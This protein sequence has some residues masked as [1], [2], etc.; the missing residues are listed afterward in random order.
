MLLIIIVPTFIAQLISTYMFYHRHWDHV[1]RYMIYTLAGEIALIAGVY[2]NV[3]KVDMEKL[4]AYAFLQYRFYPDRSFV[5]IDQEL[6]QEL[7]I[8]KSSL[9]YNLPHNLIDIGYNKNS[10]NI[11][12]AIQIDGGVLSFEVAKKRIFS[13]STYIF[14]LWMIGS[15]FILLTLSVLFA[16]NQT[17]SIV[18]LS[19]AAKKL[20]T[21]AEYTFT[22]QGATEVKTVGYALLSMKQKIEQQVKEKT[23]ILAGVSHDLKTPMTRFNLQ[24]ALMKPSRH[25]KEMKED[26]IQ[27]E[28]TINDYLKFACGE[29][30]S[31]TKLVNLSRL[32]KKIVKESTTGNIPISFSG[33]PD[34]HV[35]AIENPLSRAIINF[36]DNAKRLATKIVIKI[37]E[38]DENIVIK[39][40]DNGP[41][42][43]ISERSKVLEPFYR[44]DH[45]RN[46]DFG[47]VG[48]GMSISN[49]IITKIGGNINLSKSFMGGLLITISL[50]KNKA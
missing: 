13:S 23:K 38:T 16:R 48:L 12:V 25:T 41:G 47:G 33:S 31:P 36:I 35:I 10:E 45:S 9:Q 24:L 14:I 49:D 46:Q 5:Y 30:L 29:D 15:T 43:P 19:I 37:Y 50:P 4:H 21:G 42:I 22:P 26:V 3:N 27:M 17:R 39:I 28:K 8:L 32:L 34:L 20:S 2:K 1:K 11:E 40:H 44:I 6:S 18:R 7:S